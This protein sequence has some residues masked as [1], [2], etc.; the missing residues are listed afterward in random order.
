MNIE[1][2]RPLLLYTMPSGLGD[3]IVMGDLMSKVEA[4]IPDGRCLIVHRGNPHVK[5]WKYDDLQKHFFDLNIF[6]HIVKLIFALRKA[7]KD[8]YVVFGMQQAP[9]SLQGYFLL[10]F[11]KRLHALDYIVDFNII[12]ADI[13]IPPRGEYILDAHLNQIR[14]LLRIMVS[15]EYHGLSLPYR[16]TDFNEEKT[17]GCIAI[18]PWSGRGQSYS[19]T[20]PFEKWLLVIQYLLENRE[21]DIVVFGKDRSFLDFK[22]F[23]YKYLGESISRIRFLPSRTVLELTDV[24]KKVELLITVNTSVVHIAYALRKKMII[25]CGPTLDL[26]VPKGDHIRTVRDEEA[27]FIGGD[28]SS[29]DRRFGSVGNISVENVIRALNSINS[30]TLNGTGSTR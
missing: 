27:L 3:F 6:L 17:V 7:K 29:C 21:E 26:W 18:H 24:I 22:Q 8:N 11:L 16:I 23:L 14:D 19:Y 30:N 28:K 20:W 10:S 1:K 9:G 13:I 12:N 5:L 4:L 15:P 25:L 2:I